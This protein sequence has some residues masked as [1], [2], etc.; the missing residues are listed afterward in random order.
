MGKLRLRSSTF[1]VYVLA[2]LLLAASLTLD[3]CGGNGSADPIDPQ[4]LYAA[5]VQD[6]Q[7]MTAQKVSSN[8]TAI[9]AGNPS[10]VWENNVPGTRVLVATY[11]GSQRACASYTDGNPGCKAGQECPDY[12][13]NTWISVVPELKNLLGSAPSS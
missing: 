8:L 6:A 3:S 10:L 11:L 13:Y 12:T 7:D 5:A 4:T 2:F 9:V 1:A